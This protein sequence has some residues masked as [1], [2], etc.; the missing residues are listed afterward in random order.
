MKLKQLEG[1][2]EVKP[3]AGNK[4]CWLGFIQ[5]FCSTVEEQE[6]TSVFISM[7]QENA[8]LL[9]RVVCTIMSWSFFLLHRLLFFK[10]GI[11]Q[12]TCVILLAFNN[13]LSSAIVSE[14]YVIIALRI[15]ILIYIV[16]LL[17]CNLVVLEVIPTR[18]KN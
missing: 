4:V 14:K 10:Q 2:R 9:I 16:H 7:E 18:Y 1:C 12:V 11:K 15:R 13:Y 3:I 8:N 17:V 5:A 6:M